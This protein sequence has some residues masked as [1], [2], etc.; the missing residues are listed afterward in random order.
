MKAQKKSHTQLAR[1]ERQIM[2]AIYNLK[3]ASVSDVLKQL[4]DPPSYSAIRAMMRLLEEKGHLKHRQVGTKYV[5]RPTESKETVRKSVLKHVVT[6]LFDN[7]T[8]NAFAALL[9]IS[10]S[11]LT[12]SELKSISTMIDGA[13]ANAK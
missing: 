10:S 7:S 3:E 1:R 11:N 12:K 2:E 4:P 5:Y 13:K 8:E 9:D 6:S